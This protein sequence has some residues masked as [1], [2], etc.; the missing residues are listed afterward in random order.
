[1]GAQPGGELRLR[2]AGLRVSESSWRP[3]SRRPAA[4]GTGAGRGRWPRWTGRPPLPAGLC[5][6]PSRPGVLTATDLHEPVEDKSER[7]F[8]VAV[9]QAAAVVRECLQVV[10]LRHVTVPGDLEMLAQN[11]AGNCSGQILAGAVERVLRQVALDFSVPGMAWAES[12]ERSARQRLIDLG[13]AACTS[14]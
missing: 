8:L 2:C 10:A 9:S 12:A 11:L 13:E 5:H 4:T 14:R 3:R 6:S 1:M 7:N